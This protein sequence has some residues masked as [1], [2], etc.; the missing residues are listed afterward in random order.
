MMYIL[1]EMFKGWCVF[2]LIV[3]QLELAQGLK[4]KY[5]TSWSSKSWRMHQFNKQKNVLNM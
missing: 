5:Y 4:R 2:I 1:N 3:A